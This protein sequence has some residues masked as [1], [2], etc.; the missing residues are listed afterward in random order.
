MNASSLW[1]N[2]PFL[3]LFA[4]AEATAGAAAIVLTVTYVRNVLGR[5]ETVFAL[6]MATVGLGSSATALL[7]GRWSRHYEVRAQGEAQLH[8]NRHRWT[9]HALIAGGFGLGL[10]LLPGVLVPPLFLFSLLWVGKEPG[11]L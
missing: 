5:S 7:L 3:A 11:K 9:G 2:R 4:A 10:V 6:V 8:G 1:R